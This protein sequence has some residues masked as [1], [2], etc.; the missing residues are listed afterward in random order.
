MTTTQQFHRATSLDQALELLAQPGPEPTLLAGGTDVLV[1]MKAGEYAPERVIDIWAMR[2]ECAHL[3]DDGDTVAIGALASYSEIIESEVVSRELPTLVEACRE[4]GA[5][6]IQNRGTLGG[7]IGG[8]SPAGDSLPVLLAYDASVVLA[9]SRGT[10]VVKY[11]EFCTGYRSTARRP[12]EL[13]TEI[14]FPKPEPGTLQRWYKVGTRLAQAISKTMLAG[15]GRLDGQERIALLRLGVG[16]VAPVPLRLDRVAGA[17][18]GRPV[19]AALLDEARRLTYEEISPI[20]DVRSTAEYRQRVTGN[21]VV[22]FLE[23]LAASVMAP[24]G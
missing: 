16:S 14:R 21:L 2:P 24:S 11:A 9:S 22:R 17:A 4:I 7:N 10:R 20:D 1:W 8:S 19:H 23:E 3:R 12:D 15:V 18:V 13:I 6:Q 5:V